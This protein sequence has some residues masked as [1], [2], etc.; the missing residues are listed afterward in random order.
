[1]KARYLNQSVAEMFDSWQQD[2]TRCA[3]QYAVF[4]YLTMATYSVPS[5]WGKNMLGYLSLDIICSSKLTVFLELPSRKTLRI[6][7]Q[8]MSMDKYPSIFLS[9]MEA[10]V[11]VLHTFSQFLPVPTIL[12]IP[13]PILFFPA[14]HTPPN[15][16]S[17]G[18]LPPCPLPHLG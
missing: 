5:I 15:P 13:L 16:C 14:P 3:L 1:M 7:E 10:F 4:N 6:S 17:S 11:Y 12:G 2:S 8:I 18:L 9:Q